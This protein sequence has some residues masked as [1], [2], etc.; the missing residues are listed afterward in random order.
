MPGIVMVR[1]YGQVWFKTQEE[2]IAIMM[3]CLG[4]RD[5]V[6]RFLRTV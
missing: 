2:V 6:T 1:L 4:V 5:S 3:Y